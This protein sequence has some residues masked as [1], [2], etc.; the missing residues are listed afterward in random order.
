ME[1][2]FM[3]HRNELY[4]S[5]ALLVVAHVHGAAGQNREHHHYLAL[6]K[7]QDDDRTAWHCYE[8]INSGERFSESWIQVVNN[9]QDP[10]AVIWESLKCR[11]PNLKIQIDFEKKAKRE[12]RDFN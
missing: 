2:H 8:F 1:D 12:R 11:H 6:A 10:E 9:D 3:H 7:E 4:S 5:E